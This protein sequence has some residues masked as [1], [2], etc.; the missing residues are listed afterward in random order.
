MPIATSRPPVHCFGHIHESWG[1]KK[2]TWR[3]TEVSEIPSHF[4][5]IDNDNSELIESLVTLRPGRFDSKEEKASKERKLVQ[6]GK[7][8]IVIL[9]RI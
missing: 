2:V 5:D 8:D 9:L 6:L 7:R 3:G 1:T 4:S